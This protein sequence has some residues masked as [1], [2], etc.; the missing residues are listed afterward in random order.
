MIELPQKFKERMSSILGEKY[1]DFISSYDRQPYK[2]IRI[3]TLK[4]T[5][6]AFKEISPFELRPVP[7]E[8][9]DR[10]SVV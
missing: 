5:P 9:K 2:A 3:N 7:W 4:I 1:G 6:E 10:K 8:K